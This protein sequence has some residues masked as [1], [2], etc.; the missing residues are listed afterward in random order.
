MLCFCTLI[1]SNISRIMWIHAMN[2][3]L[4]EKHTHTFTSVSLLTT[5]KS[6]LPVSLL[7]NTMAYINF[8]SSLVHCFKV[9][10]LVKRREKSRKKTWTEKKNTKEAMKKQ[11]ICIRSWISATLTSTSLLVAYASKEENNNSNSSSKKINRILKYVHW[12]CH[13]YEEERKKLKPVRS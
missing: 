5:H 7:Q 12:K 2:S 11:F 10:H 9:H 4:K 13:A 8:F 6:I 1:N 3:R